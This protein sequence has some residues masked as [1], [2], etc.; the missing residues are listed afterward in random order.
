MYLEYSEL[1]KEA[2]L[3][4]EWK[5]VYSPKHDRLDELLTSVTGKLGLDGFVGV[6]DSQ[7]IAAVMTNRKLIAGIQFS[8]FSVG[9][10]SCKTV[11]ARE[12][13]FQKFSF[14]VCQQI[15]EHLRATCE[16]NVFATFPK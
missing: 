7:E 2:D 12:T 8:H 11:I 6:T 14:F 1:A 5:V 9:F 13:F 16:P 15:T 10:S 3:I 4:R